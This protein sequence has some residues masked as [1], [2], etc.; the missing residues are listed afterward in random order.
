MTEDS[1]EDCWDDIRKGRRVKRAYPSVLRDNNLAYLTTWAQIP[2]RAFQVVPG[3]DR[4]EA[5]KRLKAVLPDD[6]IVS[7]TPDWYQ[8]TFPRSI[9]SLVQRHVIHSSRRHR[10]AFNFP[11]PYI[12]ENRE[13]WDL[14]WGLVGKTAFVIEEPLKGLIEKRF[15]RLSDMYRLITEARFVARENRDG[16]EAAVHSIGR[17][18]GGSAKPDTF[19]LASS[20]KRPLQSEEALGVALFTLTLAYQNGLLP[21][22]FYVLDGLEKLDRR[23]AA[24]LHNILVSLERWSTI[25]CPIRALLLWDGQN[26][27]S[28]RRLNAKLAKQMRDG[29]AW[30]R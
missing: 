27:E 7:W 14:I 26:R 29:L 15:S 6:V 3:D 9:T 22:T 10:S 21:F 8:G 25:G 24:D 18:L 5:L 1:L 23:D 2:N 4:Y 11:L 19:L 30:V 20:V 17:W 28:F 16:I 13:G 12:P